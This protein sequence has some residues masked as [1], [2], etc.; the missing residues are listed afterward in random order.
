MSQIVSNPNQPW[1]YLTLD[2]FSTNG[3]ALLKNIAA[4]PTFE[5]VGLL[6]MNHIHDDTLQLICNLV[7]AFTG[8]KAPSP[9]PVQPVVGDS[10]GK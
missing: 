5:W 6:T 2:S 1:T 8:A 10:G 4:I 7:N 9:A 3:I